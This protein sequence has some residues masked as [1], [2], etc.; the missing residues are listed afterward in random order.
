LAGRVYKTTVST[1]RSAEEI[2]V[3]AHEAVR[4]RVRSLLRAGYPEAQ[5]LDLAIRGDV[6]VRLAADLLSRGCPLET[7]V[8][9]LR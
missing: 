1:S 4:L 7:A 2:P 3:G 5:A 8:R 6:A 9:I